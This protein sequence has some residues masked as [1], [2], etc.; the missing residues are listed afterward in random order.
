MPGAETVKTLP[1]DA[2]E[3]SVVVY[4]A[5]NQGEHPDPKT[6]YGGYYNAGSAIVNRGQ[7]TFVL[8]G[9]P[10]AY[11]VPMRGEL[12]RHIHYRYVEAPGMLS[13]VKTAYY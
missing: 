10:G 13:E 8:R 7:V 5:A 9:E 12:P 2:P 4:W 11:G 6:A 3:G 1:V